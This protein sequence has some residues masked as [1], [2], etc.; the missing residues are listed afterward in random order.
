MVTGLI[1]ITVQI[2]D[3]LHIS[4]WKICCPNMVPSEK[5]IK[6]FIASSHSYFCC[7]M[8]AIS[9]YCCL[10]ANVI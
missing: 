1:Q 2:P 6:R 8:A 7:F 4:H 10:P 5:S 9:I 3:N